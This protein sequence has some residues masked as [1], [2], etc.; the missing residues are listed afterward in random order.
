MCEPARPDRSVPSAPQ[1]VETPPPDDAPATGNPDQLAHDELM[2]LATEAAHQIKAPLT[3]IQT[4]LGTLMGGFAGPLQPHQR[5]L[6]EK[7]VER[8]SHGNKIVRDLVKLR[9][10]ATLA[11]DA[12][13]PLDLARVFSGVC[14]AHRDAA[15]AREVSLEV[16]L[17]T[18]RPEAAWVRGE[19]DLVREILAVLFDNA[20][21]YTPQGGRVAVRLYRDDLPG[22]PCPM[23]HVEV[24]DTGI[25]IP[26]EG[27]TRLFHEFYRAPSAKRISAEGSGLGL[28]F[29][30]RAARRMGATVHLEPGVSGGVCA[31][32]SFPSCPPPD[33]A[34]LRAS[35][36][37][38][39]G[40]AV[41]QTP[42]SRRVVVVGGVAA[43][44]KVA[45]KVMR[46]DQQAE[47]TI[48]ERGRFL[49]YSGCALPYYVSGLVNDQRRLLETP[50]GALRDSSF[51]H[52]L[53]NVRTLDMTVA[54]RIDR[55]HKTVRVRS[56]DGSERDLPYDQLVLTTGSRPVRPEVPGIDLGG[57]YTL[58]G[59]PDA[60]ALRAELL[61]P[62]VKDVVVVGAGLLGCQITEAIA[63]RG[64]RISLVEASP[65]ILGVVDPLIGLLTQRHLESHGI[66]VL[67][68][69]RVTAFEGEREVR[70][71]V[72][73]DGR[74]LPCDFV[75]LAAGVRPEVTLGEAAGLK[76]GPMGAFAVDGHLRTSDP[77]I[78]AAGDCAERPDAL[79]G[80]PSWF[81]GAAAAAIQGRIAA[82]NLCG[83][84]EEY[85]GSL[86]TAII[87]QFDATVARTGLTVQQA[88]EA[89]FDPVA[90]VVPGLDHAHFIP[91]A[92]MMVFVLVADRRTR[93]LLGAQ[94]FG[95]GHVAKRIDIVATALAAGL[96]LED[97]SRLSL[98]YAPHCA[99]ATDV[100]IAAANV[101]RDKLDGHFEGITPFELHD[102]LAR[103]DPP[104]VI[105]VRLPAELDVVRLSGSR[106]IPLG[107]LRQRLDEL[108]RDRT[109]VLVCKLGL[110]G[111]EASLI[112]KANGFEDVRVLDG[113]LDAWPFDLERLE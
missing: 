19:P 48:V 91:D 107:A 68:D 103:P 57:I 16:R 97:V 56:F 47:V 26:P 87:K 58:H 43:G 3:T 83:G 36:G 77:D 46:L 59:V 41:S 92:Q 108:P 69:A 71:V 10:L 52:D 63:M 12:L 30:F 2:R 34:V 6:V 53:K 80:Q 70:Q 74:R 28:A 65:T 110:R 100:V 62:H 113:G 55:A 102:A 7:A 84:A 60:E 25:G 99:M 75:V 86:G 8:C 42:P 38:Q 109:I 88:R 89:G 32:A 104:L 24:V 66:R 22:A 51:F 4:I 90:A 79:T 23:L 49:A 13:R 9:S 33:D 40:D 27:Y 85:P 1:P 61:S 98:A 73:H 14:E 18:T 81:P 11:D 96:S 64:A 44:P 37:E 5:W 50:L 82:V 101:M 20:I 67:T 72:L 76:I 106:F 105:D 35:G 21:K 93:R 17:E 31:R 15:A 111:Y 112:L 29:A 54:V 45:A 94:V 78:Y 39:A 95:R